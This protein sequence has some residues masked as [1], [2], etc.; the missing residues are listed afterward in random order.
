MLTLIWDW[1]GVGCHFS[2]PC[3]WTLIPGW[4]KGVYILRTLQCL[5]GEEDDFYFGGLQIY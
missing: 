3:L 2:L 4:D 5:E 1:V